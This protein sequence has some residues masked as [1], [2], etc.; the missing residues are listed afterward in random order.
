M[1]SNKSGFSSIDDYIA[2]FP[3]EIQVKLQ[4]LRAVIKAAAPEAEVSLF[5][6]VVPEV[7]QSRWIL[8]DNRPTSISFRDPSKRS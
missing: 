8:P 3:E 6:D 7:N 5:G 4:D 1:D 2:G